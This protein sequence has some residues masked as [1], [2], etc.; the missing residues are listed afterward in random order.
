M[1][2]NRLIQSKLIAAISG[3]GLLAASA[4]VGAFPTGRD[5]PYTGIFFENA[6]NLVDNDQNG[7]VS[8]GDQFYGILN[9][10]NIKDATS[11]SGQFGPN[12]WSPGADPAEITGYF[13]T[14]VIDVLAPA[15][16]GIAGESNPAIVLGPT[17]DPN[18]YLASGEVM[19]WYEDTNINYNNSTVSTGLSTATDGDLYAS[20]GMGDE[21]TYWYSLASQTPPGSGNDVGD[22]FLG[23]DFVINPFSNMRD[24]NDPNENFEDGDVQ[25]FANTEL[26]QEAPLGATNDSGQRLWEFGSNDPA[27]ISVPSPA[28]IALFGLGLLGLAFFAGRRPFANRLEG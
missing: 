25:M 2:T 20:L 4:G 15:E 28:P 26:F 23:L 9:V 17:A 1:R 12:I 11:E 24:V 3:A 14:E 13:A 21:D 16:H 19:R 6:E 22:S 27:V 7:Q 8:V 10:Q 18:G 5:N